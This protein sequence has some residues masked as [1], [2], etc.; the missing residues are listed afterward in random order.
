MKDHLNPL[1]KKS[2]GDVA[3]PPDIGRR[4]GE[5]YRPLR[6]SMETCIQQRGTGIHAGVPVSKMDLSKV[7]KATMNKPKP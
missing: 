1:V 5:P 7:L 2:E 3:L 4:Q 6:K